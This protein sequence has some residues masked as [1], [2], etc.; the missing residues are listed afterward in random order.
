MNLIKSLVVGA[1]LLGVL[2][3]A[4][5]QAQQYVPLLSYRVGPYAAG[6]SGFF[7]GVIDYFNLVNAN[8][9]I[10]GVKMQWDECETEY[11]ASRGVECYERNKTK[12]GGATLVEPLSTGIAYGILD[13]VA[14]DK[15][16]MTTMGY[17][18][19][20]AANG[21][22]FPYVFPL[23]SSYWSQAAGM[24]KYLG[25]KSGGM[26]KLKGKKIVHLYHD[27]AFGKE[28]MP[29]LEEQ[30]KQYGFEL[31]KI[32]VAHPGNEQQSQWLQIRQAKPD[33]VILWGWG[34]MNAVAIKTAQRNGFPRENML[35]V[36]W[37]G[38]EED[39]IPAGDAAKGYSSMTF[40]T[41]GNYPVLDDIRK[42]VYGAGKGNLDD[43]TRI[44]S[45]YHMRGVTAA[46][47]WVEAI[48]NAQQ[49]Y[50]KGKVMTGEQVRWG[51]ENLNVDPARQKALGAANMFPPV[52]TS[53]DNHEG[54]GAVKV[55]QWNGTKWQAITKD[56]VLGD[57]ALVRKLVDDSSA[58]YAAEKKITPACMGG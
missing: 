9:G 12:N 14:T 5:A 50:G 29:V 25:E 32:P 30:A 35:G 52:K 41:P 2:G 4:A 19:S 7:G 11:N 47:L 42:K 33:F 58:K 55:Q 26:D 16:P 8:G 20:D 10:N 27:S 38:S 48:R 43:K 34:V 1:S 51:F 17:G 56:W 6:G 13:R 22:V 44:G 57:S 23:I 31:I 28:P 21:K 37:A 3:T 24:V 15:I 46:I 18:R 45:V 36:W 49:K 53:C 54:S 39:A 40:N